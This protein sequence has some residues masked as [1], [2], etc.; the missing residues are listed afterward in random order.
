MLGTNDSIQ[1]PEREQLT[2][3]SKDSVE[4]LWDAL[5]LCEA[6]AEAQ[7]SELLNQLADPIRKCYE[8]GVEV[9]TLPNRTSHNLDKQIAAVFLKRALTDLR[10]IWRLVSQGYTS[11]AGSVAAATFENALLCAYVAG[12]S[13]AAQ[14]IQNSNSGDVPFK[15][16]ELAINL[17]KLRQK[18]ESKQG[19]I[20]TERE[21]EIHW[22]TIYAQYKWLCKIKHPNFLSALHDSGASAVNPNDYI[23]MAVP[24]TRDEDISNKVTIIST[25]VGIVYKAILGFAISMELDED[26]QRV[27]RWKERFISVLDGVSMAMHSIRDIPLPF[28][29]SGTA[30][31]NEYTKLKSQQSE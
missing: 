27:V 8:C 5:A 14:K 24:D 23:I 15:A 29:L 31:V 19:R 11:Q 16:K 4:G 6:S 10:A 17:A 7:L 25:S 12:N 21:V 9:A 2:P 18:A 20:I 22:R 1:L 3:M 28:D 26:H 13:T 30:L